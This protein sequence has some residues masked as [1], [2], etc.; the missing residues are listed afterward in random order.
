MS[1]GDGG[2]D[3]GFYKDP[4]IW[5]YC[6]HQVWYRKKLGANMTK[7]CRGSDIEITCTAYGVISILG[8]N[9]GQI[10]EGV[11]MEGFLILGERVDLSRDQSELE[12]IGKTS[13]ALPV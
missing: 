5:K 10:G 12:V 3:V 9:L 8:G 6:K 7:A 1:L 13:P 11:V 4:L 2:D